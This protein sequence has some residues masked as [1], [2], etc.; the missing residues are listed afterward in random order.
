MAIQTEG[1]KAAIAKKF[2]KVIHLLQNAYCVYCDHR[3][4]HRGCEYGILPVGM[5]GNG[6]K[7]F[8]PWGVDSRVKVES[9]KICWPKLP[10]VG[11]R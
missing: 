9:G 6:C 5:D 1:E 8:R 2:P 3:G 4:R 10:S 11:K 7:Y